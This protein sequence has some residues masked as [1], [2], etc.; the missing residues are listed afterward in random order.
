MANLT[1][2]ALKVATNYSEA[3]GLDFLSDFGVSARLKAQPGS[4]GKGIPAK[5]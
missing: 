1:G 5:E 4:L 2:A 3:T